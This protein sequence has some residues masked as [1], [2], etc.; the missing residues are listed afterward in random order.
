M[1]H[2]YDKIRD[3]VGHEVVCVSYGGGVNVAVE[4][5][6]CGV[7]IIDADREGGDA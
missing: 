5:E 4:C 7:V 6:T 3:H 1:S 2:Q